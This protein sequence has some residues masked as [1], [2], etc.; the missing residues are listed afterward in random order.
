MF[1]DQSSSVSLP[2]QSAFESAPGCLDS[3]DHPIARICTKGTVPEPT[4]DNRLK[5]AGVRASGR[6]TVVQPRFQ[7]GPSR[8]TLGQRDERRESDAGG[9]SE[10]DLS[11]ET[12]ALILSEATFS[13]N[14]S[15]AQTVTEQ[16]TRTA[17]QSSR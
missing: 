13:Y 2:F 16:S 7:L 3:N 5:L 9:A 12:H 4:S 15:Q 10:P 8:S 17:L 1:A 6:G 11:R 14:K